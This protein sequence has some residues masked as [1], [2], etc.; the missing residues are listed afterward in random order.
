M[1]VLNLIGIRNDDT[2][3]LKKA[4]RIVGLWDKGW[5]S[6]GHGRNF[7][8]EKET[9][10]S[11][12]VAIAAWPVNILKHINDKSNQ[13]LLIVGAAGQGKSKLMRLMLEMFPNPKTIFSFK[14]RDEYLKMEGNIIYADK[15]LPDPFRDSDAFT[16]AFAVA[17]GVSSAGIQSNIA[18]SLVR[19]LAQES[20]SWSNFKAN[21]EKMSKS[22]DNNTRAAAVYILQKV[23]N[24]AFDANQIVLDL[25]ATNILDFSHLNEE[26]KTFY[27]ELFL[28]QIY[29]Q[30]IEDN[31]E[32]K[33]IVCIDE[34]HRLTKNIDAS[35]SSIFG[36]MSREVR[37]FGMLWNRKSIGAVPN[38]TRRCQKIRPGQV[39][40]KAWRLPD[41][42]CCR[43]RHDHHLR[44][45]C[46]RQDQLF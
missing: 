32:R 15:S 13:N 9:E 10:M 28:R 16:S 7:R 27:A 30:V 19:R 4:V 18:L 46:K 40:D 39:Q 6:S 3:N 17:S 5:T 23:G 35:Y 29:K 26:A 2:P 31:A 33:V 37:A 21:A 1:G 44:D 45:K 12:G 41:Y 22:R 24:L 25:N 8:M 14:Q 38:D 34:A 42:I 11:R 36:E 20:N 43:G